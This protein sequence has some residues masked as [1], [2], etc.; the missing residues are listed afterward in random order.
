M[1]GNFWGW[2]RGQATRDAVSTL[3]FPKVHTFQPHPCLPQHMSTFPHWSIHPIQA[4]T[5]TT[6]PSLLFI[7]LPF[8]LGRKLAE[9]PVCT[10]GRQ[11]VCYHTRALNVLITKCAFKNLPSAVFAAIHHV[12][13]S[14]Q[15]GVENA[16]SSGS[17]LY[18]SIKAHRCLKQQWLISL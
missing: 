1:T 6:S 11:E 12:F 9:V 14:G 4:S 5:P 7:P 16:S 17:H 3:W 13:L 15:V 10:H 8:L 18:N 2:K